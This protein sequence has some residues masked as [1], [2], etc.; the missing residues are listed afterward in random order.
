MDRKRIVS[1]FENSPLFSL[2]KDTNTGSVSKKLTKT[3]DFR[4]VKYSNTKGRNFFGNHNYS[5]ELSKPAAST[6]QHQS[7]D[8]LVCDTLK[9][10]FTD[11]LQSGS[12]PKSN[13]SSSSR[14]L[15]TLTGKNL[16]RSVIEESTLN[17]NDG[18]YIEA[19]LR[20]RENSATGTKTGKCIAY[21]EEANHSMT[22]RDSLS[23]CNPESKQFFVLKTPDMEIDERRNENISYGSNNEQSVITESPEGDISTADNSMPDPLNGVVAFVDV[24]TSNENRFDGVAQELEKM[25]A[26]IFMNGKKS[27]INLIEKHAV[28]FVSVLWVDSCKQTWSRVDEEQFPAMKKENESLLA[29]LRGKIKRLK[30]L[31]PKAFDV[32]LHHSGKLEGKRKKRKVTKDKNFQF[33]LDLML[34]ENTEST[35]T[36]KMTHESDSILNSPIANGSPFLKQ[37]QKRLAEKRASMDQSPDPVRFDFG[38]DKEDDEKEK[39][40]ER[41]EGKEEEEERK[42]EVDNN[43]EEAMQVD[44]VTVDTEKHASGHCS[45]IEARDEVGVNNGTED[46]NGRRTTKDLEC[47]MHNREDKRR[48]EVS[49]ITNSSVSE[50]IRNATST[51]NGQQKEELQS[52]K[53]KKKRKLLSKM[54][55]F[56]HVSP[57]V[58]G[59]EAKEVT[60][61][62]SQSP[63]RCNQKQKET[64]KT[65]DYS[66]PSGKRKR[67]SPEESNRKM[68]KQH[69]SFAGTGTSD[70]MRQEK[71]ISL[72]TC[73]EYVVQTGEPIRRSAKRQ[74]KD[75]TNEQPQKRQR[76]NG[77]LSDRP[78]KRQFQESAGSDGAENGQ[79]QNCSGS[80]KLSSLNVDNSVTTCR[81][82]SWRG[83]SVNLPREIVSE[84]GALQS[85]SV[86][87]SAEDVEDRKACRDKKKSKKFKLQK[88]FLVM[89]SLHFSEQKF[90]RTAVSR[91]G[92]FNLSESVNAATTHVIAGSNRR[93]LNII[94]ALIEGAWVLSPDWVCASFEKGEWLQEDE[95]ELTKDFPMAKANRCS[96]QDT[97]RSIAAQL[98]TD[99]APFFVADSTSPSKDI[100]LKLIRKCGGQFTSC[101]RKAEIC[102]GKC[103]EHEQET[104]IRQVEEKWLLDCIMKSERLDVSNYL[105]ARNEYPVKR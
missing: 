31:Q 55:C 3:E 54:H 86:E 61:A 91:L 19:F 101:I 16:S 77:E 18:S 14:H 71:C 67:E 83:K 20:N 81:N 33:N 78:A 99:Q 5:T 30:S 63:I 32:D 59:E 80:G 90:I 36:A 52:A 28:H 29:S 94:N 26:I 68:Q 22:A 25:G 76:T 95:F 53:A 24:R 47:A 9:K 48:E 13:K 102:I 44:E 96:R 70:E 66:A 104:Q 100:I 34:C 4:G 93:T 87:K 46:C 64:V 38:R 43:N 8:L 92:T 39:G 21:D 72:T 79:E 42:E 11:G 7:C 60:Q 51:D 74:L 97:G 75:D 49:L 23:S 17:S 69:A 62:V 85:E 37:V 15:S 50:V 10:V 57:L 41:E 58:N 1:S 45:D 6:P 27:T 82:I 88:R 56:K 89:T 40:K 2:A 35:D 12:D 103:N 84:N 73:K 98:L 105:I 65:N